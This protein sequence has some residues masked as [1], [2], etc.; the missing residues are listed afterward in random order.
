MKKKHKK[1]RS[2]RT[3]QGRGHKAIVTKVNRDTS[4]I[5]LKNHISTC[6]QNL[7]GKL[8]GT[9]IVLDYIENVDGWSKPQKTEG[10]AMSCSSKKSSGLCPKKISSQI[11]C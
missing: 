9:S 7:G 10:Y 11:M 8:D 6:I 4:L 5:D 1:A 3:N 2:L